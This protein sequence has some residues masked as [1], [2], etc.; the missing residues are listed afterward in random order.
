MWAW[1]SHGKAI[2]ALVQLSALAQGDA[3]VFAQQR[4][5]GQLHLVDAPL[6]LTGREL[7][8]LQRPAL[9]GQGVLVHVLGV[10]HLDPGRFRG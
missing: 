1:Q 3:G 10:E 8:V 4:N 9:L 2:D 7:L 6:E 5:H